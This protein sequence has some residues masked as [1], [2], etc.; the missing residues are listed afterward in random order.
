MG[1]RGRRIDADGFKDMLVET[2]GLRHVGKFGLE[3]GA[4]WL[5]LARRSEKVLGTGWQHQP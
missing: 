4:A 3:V 2:K 1:F 5:R